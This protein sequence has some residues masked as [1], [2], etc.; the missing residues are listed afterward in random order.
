M[1]VILMFFIMFGVVI[2]I[3]LS[4]LHKQTKHFKEIMPKDITM[5][6]RVS[7]VGNEFKKLFMTDKAHLVNFI[8]INARKQISFPES[9]NPNSKFYITNISFTANI[10][11]TIHTKGH[12]G[13]AIAGGIIAGGVGAVIG[14][15]RKKKSTIERTEH[16]TPAY[17]TL[18]DT[19]LKNTY[20]VKITMDTA[21]YNELNNLYTLNDIDLQ[22]LQKE[23]GSI[24][25]NVKN[26][27]SNTEPVEKRLERLKAL[28]YKDLITKSD[29]ENKKKQ[30]LGI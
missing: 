8:A 6:T 25:D 11:E 1:I 2:W 29:Y 24:E 30:I 14:A 15:S 9:G 19:N 23:L 5:F 13:S 16:K 10:T 22:N 20:T 21:K 26:I 4:Y 18:V 28:L 3:Y 7:P 27:D 17:V 12:V